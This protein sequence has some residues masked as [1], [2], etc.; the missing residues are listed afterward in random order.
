MAW[1]RDSKKDQ[2]AAS[3]EHKRQLEFEKELADLNALVAVWV[4]GEKWL[5]R[6]LLNVFDIVKLDADEELQ[7]SRG[8]DIDS[9]LSRLL[10]KSPDHETYRL[11]NAALR[12]RT[13]YRQNLIESVHPEHEKSAEDR[14]QYLFDDIRGFEKS[15]GAVAKYNVENAV[16]NVTKRR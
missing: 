2:L 12:A 10:V 6:A 11:V 16:S 8:N 13:S 1:E 4:E 7:Y 15:V 5:A 9:S 14:R 3:R